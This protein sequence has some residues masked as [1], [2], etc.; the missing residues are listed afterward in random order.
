MKNLSRLA[1]ATVVHFFISADLSR[2]ATEFGGDNDVPTWRVGDRWQFSRKF[3][4]QDDFI[5]TSLQTTI[6]LPITVDDSFWKDVVGIQGV[7]TGA[8]GFRTTRA[9]VCERTSPSEASIKASGMLLGLV[10]GTPSL[11]GFDHLDSSD[12]GNAF[13]WVS[14][15]DLAQLREQFKL[16][17][18]GILRIPCTGVLCGLW[19]DML[20]TETGLVCGDNPTTLTL[21]LTLDH[22]PPGNNPTR[23][24]K[25]FID[26]SD[27]MA[28]TGA[29]DVINLASSIV[30]PAESWTLFAL[31]DG[32]GNAWSV[33]GSASGTQGNATSG[34]PYNNG[35]VSFL[36]QDSPDAAWHGAAS[37]VRDRIQFSVARD[38]FTPWHS[39]GGGLELVDFPIIQTDH[40]RQGIN[41]RLSG[42]FT[43][44]FPGDLADHNLPLNVDNIVKYDIEL[45]SGDDGTSSTARLMENSAG[46]GEPNDQI[47]YTPSLREISLW[48][49][50]GTLQIDNHFKR[51]ISVTSFNTAV[52]SFAPA[53]GDSSIT[54]DTITPALVRPG[55]PF[56]V[57]GTASEGNSITATILV[58]GGGTMP[59]TAPISGGA[60]SL[61]L[62]APSRNDDSPMPSFFPSRDFGSFGIE[63]VSNGAAPNSRKVGTVR[64]AS[65]YVGRIVAAS[66]PARLRVSESA[67]NAPP[68]I[69]ILDAQGK[70]MVTAFDVTV[71][72]FATSD[73]TALSPVDYSSRNF[74]S[75]TILAGQSYAWPTLPIYGPA[76]TQYN[77]PIIDNGAGEPSIES[78][79][80]SI[81][82]LGTEPDASPFPGGPSLGTVEIQDNDIL[83]CPTDA[84]A[85]FDLIGG[86]AVQVSVGTFFLFYTTSCTDLGCGCVNYGLY[87]S[88]ISGPIGVISAGGGSMQIQAFAPGSAT[89]HLAYCNP[90]TLRCGHAVDWTIN[91]VGT[92]TPTP[93]PT[94]AF[95]VEPTPSAQPS[96]TRSPT[97]SPTPT[98][99]PDPTSVTKTASPTPTATPS[100]TESLTPSPTPTKSPD[101]T[102]S[103]E[104]TLSPSPTVSPSP[105][106]P[107]TPSPTPFNDSALLSQTVPSQIPANNLAPIELVFKN[108]G[109]TTWSAGAGYKVLITKDPCFS[110]ESSSTIE[111]AP[112]QM[113]APGELLTLHAFVRGAGL[114]SSTC[115]IGG[116]MTQQTGSGPFGQ[117]FA[118]TFEIIESINDAIF[119]STSL[120]PMAAPGQQFGIGITFYNSGNTY[121]ASEGSYV[122]TLT[123]DCSLFD[124]HVSILPDEVVVSQGGAHQF[125]IPITLPQTPTSCTVQVQMREPITGLFGEAKTLV[126][127]VLAPLNPARDWTVFE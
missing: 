93:A 13:D 54:L 17:G 48:E 27:G 11:I 43:L 38:T 24:G 35:K 15:G 86:G 45:L 34:V 68:P 57:T 18:T 46:S 7:N 44:D 6:K 19:C 79:N 95:T 31:S 70:P 32:P 82:G 72:D 92:P 20:L 4:I 118:A 56:T 73:G 10:N 108:T 55:A 65:P 124:F 105:T 106:E 127:D 119:V 71:Q 29:G 94:A 5:I 80:G 113:T 81:L 84:A 120:P 30:A 51:K 8:P 9:Y 100:P 78:F 111:L 102:Q 1:F 61:M 52:Q 114:V 116:T 67:G 121:W 14:V 76:A 87:D 123:D 3:V 101:P 126:I 28:P 99:S 64:L 85:P 22:N 26:Q 41:R 96:P 36:I 115:E 2:A 77:I 69:A 122:L 88:S 112:D 89:V 125:I 98:F 60:F 62:Q 40:A 75:M 49:M 42:T 107:P 66:D 50:P 25:P 59:V 33:T 74:S 47:E 12:G 117:E 104:P 90:G 53:P 109:N 91:I 39:E 16:Q 21:S 58:P 37:G 97:V 103:P 83:P 63:F 110:F 23:A